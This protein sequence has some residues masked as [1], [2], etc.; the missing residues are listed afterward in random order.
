[1][2]PPEPS[3]IAGK[4]GTTH[5]HNKEDMYERSS[6]ETHIPN[7]NERNPALQTLLRLFPNKKPQFLETILST[8][9]G[10]GIR[11]IQTL[12]NNSPLTEYSKTY[13]ELLKPREKSQIATPGNQPEEANG[14]TV[15]RLEE[16]NFEYFAEQ[17]LTSPFINSHLM[18][19]QY[20]PPHPFLNF[21]YHSFLQSRPDYYPPLNLSAHPIQPF[22]ARTPSPRRERSPS[23][24]SPPENE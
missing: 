4:S 22:H 5:G 3:P 18:R 11:A 19:L 2:K 17:T 12:L 7:T 24:C 10:D 20:P 6:N 8:C 15:A 13:D 16:Q 21:P 14:H 23:P 9:N 1:M